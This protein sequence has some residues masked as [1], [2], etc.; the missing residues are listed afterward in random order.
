[1]VING[2]PSFSILWLPS[3]ILPPT[4]CWIV[5]H[6]FPQSPALS[7]ENITCGS[8]VLPQ[9]QCALRYK[10]YYNMEVWVIIEFDKIWHRAPICQA[11]SIH[12]PRF[13]RQQG[14]KQL[15]T[16]MLMSLCLSVGAEAVVVGNLIAD[17]CFSP[18][19]TGSRWERQHLWASSGPKH[20]MQS[21]MFPRK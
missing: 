10:V 8:F 2:L 4:R 13:L 18:L 12:C 1:M 21:T 14:L 9:K 16:W 6:L 15:L 20:G 7:F 19:W 11:S 17:V 5:W 3:V